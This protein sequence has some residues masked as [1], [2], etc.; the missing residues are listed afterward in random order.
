[1]KIPKF[2]PLA[3]HYTVLTLFL[4]GCNS[5]GS[6][7]ASSSSSVTSPEESNKPEV[8]TQ[9]ESTKPKASL[10]EEGTHYTVLKKP[11][12]ADMLPNQEASDMQNTVLEFF[13]YGCP[14]C[15]HIEEPLAKWKAKVPSSVKLIRVPAIW[16]DSM[17]LHAQ[18][19]YLHSNTKQSE[20]LHTALF[21]PNHQ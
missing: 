19:Y 8:A 1:M 2:I 11:I 21:A 16:S 15:Q 5:G 14:H 9:V 6:E 7:D 17:Q 10:Y 4:L 3:A 18:M 20:E 13:W 12:T